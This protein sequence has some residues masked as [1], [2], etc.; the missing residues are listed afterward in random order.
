MHCLTCLHIL[1]THIESTRWWP[2]VLACGFV[3][4]ISK[5]EDML[6]MQQRPLSLLSQLYQVR[7]VVRLEECMVE[8]EKWVRPHAYGFPKKQGGADAAALITLL[9]ELHT[10][11]CAALT[12][13][14]LD[15]V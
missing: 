14:G 15:Y 2:R 8:E 1:L 6:A 7:A 9:I 10:V 5:G 4:L 11:M 13:F 12:G 3:F